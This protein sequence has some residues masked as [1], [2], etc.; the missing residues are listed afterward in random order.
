MNYPT[1]YGKADDLA[2]ENER[3]V[4]ALRSM[5]TERDEARAQVQ[6]VRELHNADGFQWVGFPRAD[7]R[8]VYC[9]RCHETA[10]C[11]TIRALDG[12][13]GR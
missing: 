9:T 2:L 5:R 7:K 8:D 1:P 10:P 6:A 13:A 4:T 3:L 11:P 12:E